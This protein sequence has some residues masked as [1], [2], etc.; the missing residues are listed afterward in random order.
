MSALDSHGQPLNLYFNA[1]HRA[2]RAVHELLGLIRG[3]L[4]DGIVSADEARAL[5]RYIDANPE[6]L[7]SFPANVL[8]ER[9]HL[10]VRRGLIDEHELHDLKGL[11]E[12]TIGEHAGVH[13]FG[14]QASTTLPLTDPAPPLDYEGRHFVVTGRFIFGA[15]P[16][17]TDE[18]CRRGALC[19]SDVTHRTNVLL[20]GSLA[21]RDWKHSSFGRKIQKAM[22]LRE[23]G[24][25]VA[26]VAED[27]W[28]SQLRA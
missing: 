17:V 4:V 12:D 22:D 1:A 16:R 25:D 2:D 15:R 13:D 20:I 14:A 8:Y 9:I 24:Y 26:I 28:V 6:M 21:S 18:I 23:K 7:G 19:E 5:D 11:L 27:H 3:V 10:M